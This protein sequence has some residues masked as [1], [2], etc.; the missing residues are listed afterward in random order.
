M[1]EKLNLQV[2]D[3]VIRSKLLDGTESRKLNEGM[4]TKLN[5]MQIKGLRRMLKLE[6]SYINRAS[7][8]C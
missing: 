7:T 8:K 3:A 6:H 1:V 2:F 5:T 4:L